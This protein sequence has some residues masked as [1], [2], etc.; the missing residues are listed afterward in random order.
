MTV[1][2]FSFCHRGD[3]SENLT[4]GPG[5]LASWRSVQLLC[6]G[7]SLVSSCPRVP[8]SQAGLRPKEQL[9]TLLD[10]LLSVS[11]HPAK[12]VPRESVS[13][14]PGAW[15]GGV[16]LSPQAPQSLLRNG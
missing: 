8:R 6:P 9:C 7:P 3:G 1:C 16:A 4:A 14:T 11:V 15:E 10:T 13:D 2:T 5:S 12:K